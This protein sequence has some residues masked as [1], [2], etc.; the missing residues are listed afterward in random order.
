MAAP[1]DTGTFTVSPA[2]GVDLGAHTVK[3]HQPM[4]N[5]LG[6]SMVTG[7][8]RA[9]HMAD[10]TFR[11][12]DRPAVLRIDWIALRCWTQGRAD[13]IEVRLEGPSLAR[14]RVVNCFH[15]N[16]DVFIAHGSVPELTF[17]MAQ[18]APG[19]VYRVDYEVAFA[20]LAISE[21]LPA[22]G[23][24]P[25]LEHAAHHLATME[26]SAS[27]RYTAPLRKIRRKLV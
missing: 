27:W 13:A 16:P 15:L 24:F 17:D 14:L 6:L 1:L 20:A 7:T 10:I 26:Q 25:T 21:V 5:R 4:R 11:P 12:T 9:A 8:L 19:I 22:G 18:I 2:Q 23:R 3:E